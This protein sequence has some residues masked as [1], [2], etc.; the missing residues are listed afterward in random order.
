[1]IGIWLSEEDALVD[2]CFYCH[3]SSANYFKWRKNLCLITCCSYAANIIPNKKK[4]KQ[5]K[6]SERLISG[7]QV[8]RPTVK[9]F[10]P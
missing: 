8:S 10:R 1:M 9:A 5:D 4:T 3:F 6:L 2:Y 7:E